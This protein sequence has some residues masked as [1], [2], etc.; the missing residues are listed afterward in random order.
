MMTL[1]ELLI[2]IFCDGCA[3]CVTCRLEQAAPLEHSAQQVQ[4][5][6]QPQIPYDALAA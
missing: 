1:A 4:G 5:P 3:T 6:K 2:L